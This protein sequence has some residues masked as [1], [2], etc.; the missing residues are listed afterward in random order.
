MRRLWRGSRSQ[1]WVVAAAF[2][3]AGFASIRAIVAT[4][5]FPGSLAVFPVLLSFYQLGIAPAAR[6]I[7]LYRYHSPML[8]A[9]IRTRRLYE[10][11]GGTSFDYL[12]QLRW[13]D[14]G[15]SASRRIMIH[16]LEG[17]LDIARLVAAGEIAESVQVS[18]TSYFFSEQSARR[19]GFRIRPAGI[20]L[21]LNLLLNALDITVLYSFA[22]GRLAIPNLLRARE[23]V[24][25]GWELVARRA[26]IEAVIR[27][28][29]QE[30]T[31][32]ETSAAH[33]AL[34]A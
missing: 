14:R 12:M 13:R 21:R 26:V 6:L 2:L 15:C 16:Y 9:T 4:L 32:R 1:Q 3:I 5:G 33:Q 7:G 19:I 23:A 30:S 24:I 11:H 17:L 8:K 10:V 20:R 34:C 22:K 28:L 31:A 27:K 18:G 25:S 29:R